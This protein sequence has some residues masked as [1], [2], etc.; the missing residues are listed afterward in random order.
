MVKI[1]V[2]KIDPRFINKCIEV[3]FR[4][5]ESQLGVIREFLI[6]NQN[7]GQF[8]IWNALN[9]YNEWSNGCKYTTPCT[10]LSHK[11]IF[12]DNMTLYLLFL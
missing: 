3:S 10:F 5:Y 1:G 6:I 4:I 8:Q 9:V 11:T 12:Q 2:S 7:K